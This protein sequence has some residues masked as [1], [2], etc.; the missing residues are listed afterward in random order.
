MDSSL[1]RLGWA[2]YYVSFGELYS[3]SGNAVYF[4]AENGPRVGP[5]KTQAKKVAS[6]LRCNV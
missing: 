5:E 4:A 1:D 6:K 2:S 3:L